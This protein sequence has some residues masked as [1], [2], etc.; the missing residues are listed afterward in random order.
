MADALATALAV[1]G[2]EVLARIARLDGYH[3]LLIRAD[4]SQSDTGGISYG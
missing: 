2:T 1:G 3:A 4:G